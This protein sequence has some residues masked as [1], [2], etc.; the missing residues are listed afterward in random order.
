MDRAVVD[1]TWPETMALRKVSDRALLFLSGV[2]EYVVG[3]PLNLLCNIILSVWYFFFQITYSLYGFVSKG[4]SQFPKL[5][6]LVDQYLQ[7]VMPY[8][9]QYW[10]PPG[11]SPCQ[12]SCF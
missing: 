6:V 9:S 7:T 2:L 12:G 5:Y 11:R 10:V 3:F 1:V 8:S 4:Y